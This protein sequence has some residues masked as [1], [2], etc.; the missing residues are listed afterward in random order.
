MNKFLKKNDIIS[1]YQTGFRPNFRSEDGIARLVSDIESGFQEK[2]HTGVVYID[3]KSAFDRVHTHTLINKLHKLEFGSC[4]IG[5][6]KNYLHGRRISIKRGGLI[7]KQA[8][9][10]NGVPQ[11][12]ILSPLLFSI[13]INDLPGSISGKVRVNMFADDVILWSTDKDLNKIRSN[14]QNATN[15]VSNWAQENKMILSSSKTSCQLFSLST[16]LKYMKLKLKVLGENLQQKK[17]F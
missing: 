5:F 15:S 1:P 12:A 6:F 11:G 2:K 16:K 8:R 10:L 14:L 17:L 3:F 9:L 4:M 7:S 13:Y